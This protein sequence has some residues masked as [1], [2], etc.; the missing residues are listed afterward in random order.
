MIR[1]LLKEFYFKNR[2]ICCIKRLWR[3]FLAGSSDLTQTTL[4]M[5]HITCI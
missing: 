2:F 5:H 3:F 4:S 1:N